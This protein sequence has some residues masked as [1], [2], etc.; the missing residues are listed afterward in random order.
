MDER[1]SDEPD[2]GFDI[3]GSAYAELVC[4]AKTCVL[5]F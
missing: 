3:K 4:L 2:L 5:A 1:K